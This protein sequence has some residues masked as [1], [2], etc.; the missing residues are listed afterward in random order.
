MLHQ[1]RII[2]ALAART[3]W[4]FGASDYELLDCRDYSSAEEA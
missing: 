1:W 3:I 4:T 2:I